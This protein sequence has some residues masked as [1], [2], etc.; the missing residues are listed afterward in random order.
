MN[1]SSGA[2]PYSMSVQEAPT[3]LCA[4]L[5]AARHLALASSIART[6]ISQSRTDDARS[7]T[8][9][10]GPPRDEVTETRNARSSAIAHNDEDNRT[11]KVRATY[12]DQ[13]PP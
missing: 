6:H 1:V 7:K 12:H 5:Y 13:T 4:L 10:P 9:S 2:G 8:D 3:F 11:D